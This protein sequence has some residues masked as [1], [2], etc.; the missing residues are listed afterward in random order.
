MYMRTNIDLDDE[1]IEEAMKITGIKVKKHLV[2]EAL[3]V[4]IR[5]KKRR[6]ISELIGKIEFDEDYDYKALRKSKYQK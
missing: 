4:L 3:K 6:P 5:V 2:D 1:L